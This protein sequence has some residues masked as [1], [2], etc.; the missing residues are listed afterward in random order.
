MDCFIA[1]YKDG[2]IEKS[3]HFPRSQFDQ[4]KAE[5]W[6]SKNNIQNFW[7]IFEV[8]EPVNLSEHE[9]KFSGEVGFDITLDRLIPHI[10][11]KKKIV[12]DSYGGDLFEGYRIMDYIN[13][14]GGDVEVGVLGVCMSA[15]T[16][17]PIYAKNSWA[18]AN[19]RFMIHKPWAVVVGDDKFMAQQAD[20]LKG[21]TDNLVKIY[22]KKSGKTAAKVLDLMEK[23]SIIT[24]KE[25]KEFGLIS[26]INKSI[27]ELKNE[28][29]NEELEKRM[30]ALTEKTNS[31]WDNIK[32]LF[33]A[34]KEEKD[35]K[36][37]ELMEKIT[38]LETELSELKAEKEAVEKKA[39]ALDEAKA[40]FETITEELKALR[41][42]IKIEGRQNNFKQPEK[43]KAFDAEEFKRVKDKLNKEGK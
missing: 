6:L 40:E 35:D 43:T 33:D 32:N 20:E 4:A 9:V 7:F 42:E 26:K 31:V 8:N 18:T 10:Q 12:I 24:A 38:A 16:L 21:E 28:K 14:I 23:D 25:A 15:A 22:S 37:E 2:E 19:S 34:K 11:A 5:A 36:T 30:E 17:I 3:F 1:K 13:H 39:Q 27:V 41:T 29:M